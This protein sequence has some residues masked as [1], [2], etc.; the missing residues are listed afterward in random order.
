[1][2]DVRN[3]IVGYTQEVDILHD[4]SIV[5][6]D[7]KVICIIGPNGAG[8]STLLKAIFGFM[9]PRSGSVT[10]NGQD[11]TGRQPFD[12]VKTGIAFLPQS[13]GVCP[14]LTVEQNLMLGAWIYRN[15]KIKIRKEYERVLDRY[16][17]LRTKQSERAA[18][19]SG[20]EQ[21]MLDF[22]KAMMT[23]PRCI[24]AD[25]PTAGVASKFYKQIYEELE[26]LASVES[27]NILL[28]DQNIRAAVAISDYVY[29]LEQGKIALEGPREQFESG[30]LKRVV[31]SW[32]AFE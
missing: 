9:K 25:E 23:A 10:Y 6:P 8:K 24:L 26:A 31:Q 7:S 17:F 21:K 28:V 5:A 27:K 16:P 14:F 30:S 4:V 12:L 11:I 29:V 1:M 18:S 19:L 2:L 15:D 22:A 13:S 3:L 20:G 32:L